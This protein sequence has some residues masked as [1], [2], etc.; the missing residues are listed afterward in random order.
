MFLGSYPDLLPNL[1]DARENTPLEDIPMLSSRMSSL[2]VRNKHK[3]RDMHDFAQIWGSLEMVRGL[4]YHHSNFLI[5][6]QSLSKKSSL[7]DDSPLDHEAIAYINRLGQMHFFV[8]SLE[9][10]QVCPKIDELFLIRNKNTAHR[11]ID[12]PRKDSKFEQIWQAGCFMRR[13][14]SGKVKPDFDPNK[15]MLKDMEIFLSPQRYLSEEA[16]VSYQL[17]SNDNHA[18]FIPQKDHP[19]ILKEIEAVYTQLFN[20]RN[21]P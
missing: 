20:D 12:A 2:I 4:E 5:H 19:I 17:L 3:I 16:F 10:L 11:S 8:N 14:F 15:D 13:I 18:T 21:N 9:L 6:L 1:K 7:E